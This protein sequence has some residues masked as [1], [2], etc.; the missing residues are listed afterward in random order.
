MAEAIIGPIPDSWHRHQPL[1]V[2]M[3]AN[4]VFHRNDAGLQLAEKGL[5][6]DHV[7]ASCA[8]PPAPGHQP[9]AHE[10]HS[11]PDRARP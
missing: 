10:T 8:A 5:E 2:T 7:A 1:V 4:T 6:S 11:S 9:R 3:L